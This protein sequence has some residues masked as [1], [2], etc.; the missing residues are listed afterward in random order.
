MN[1]TNVTGSPN[2]Q[3]LDHLLASGDP[4]AEMAAMAVETGTAERKTASETRRAYEAEEASEDQQQVDA[5]HQK[6]KDIESEG[7]LD[8]AGM[9]GQGVLDA[10]GGAVGLAMLGSDSSQAGMAEAND[11]SSI[12]HAAGLGAHGI[13]TGFATEKRAAEAND[14]ANAALCKANADRAKEAAEDMHDAEKDA[15]DYVKAGLDFYRDYVS[16]D[17]QTQAA[18]L[19]RA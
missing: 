11:V 16:T 7:W 14:D 2:P 10:T 4:G 9:I 17:A 15:A 13:A 3:V 6:A 8:A 1:I 5:M 18:A 12:F 19:H